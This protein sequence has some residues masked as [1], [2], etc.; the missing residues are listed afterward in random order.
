MARVENARQYFGV[1]RMTEGGSEVELPPRQG[2]PRK[3]S[4]DL[5][6]EGSSLCGGSC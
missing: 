2:G 6:G 4:D 1:V 5:L 3:P